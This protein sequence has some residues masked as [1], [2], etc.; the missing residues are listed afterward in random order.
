MRV[1]ERFPAYV[2]RRYL[3]SKG[4][5]RF[6]FFLTVVAVFGVAVGIAAL[7]VVISVMSGFSSELESKLVS[8]NPHITVMVSGAKPGN[9]I[10]QIRSNFK[11]ISEIKPFVTGE[12]IVQP[13][14]GGTLSAAGA[15]VLGLTDIPPRM[16]ERSKFYWGGGISGSPWWQRFIPPLKRGVVL[17]NEMLYQVGVHPDFGDRVWLIAPFGSVDP[18][19]NPAPEKREY[20]VVGGFRSGIFEYDMKYIIMSLAEAR[21]LLK[22]QGRYGFQIMLSDTGNIEKFSKNLQKYLGKSFEVSGWTEKNRRLFAALKLERLA[23]SFLLFLIIIIASFSVVG[24]VLMIFFSKRRDLAVLMSMGATRR[25]ISRTFLFH[26]GWIGLAG[27]VIGTVAGLV[28]C[29]IIERSDIVL[30]PSYYLDRL[31]VSVNVPAVLLIALG[32]VL[33]SVLAAYYPARRA[34]GVDPVE[35]LRHE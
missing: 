1:K 16:T 21:R 4:E 32:G 15:R 28:I 24:V 30:P 19:G 7:I 2:A 6:A 5:P 11:G 22:D 29:Y 23:M 27:A 17:G 33:I 35:L 34:A 31:P 9:F 26:G 3:L 13:K 20:K 8:F 18:L 12:V 14:G 25:M 10:S